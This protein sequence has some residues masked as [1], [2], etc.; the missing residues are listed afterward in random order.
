MGWVDVFKV[1]HVT[2]AVTFFGFVLLGYLITVRKQSHPQL[3]LSTNQLLPFIDSIIFSFL[4]LSVFWGTVLVY[5][6]HFTFHTPWVVAAY[7]LSATFFAVYGLIIVLRKKICHQAH[8]KFTKLL[9]HLL[10]AL[11]FIM[12]IF[13]IHDAVTKQTY[14]TFLG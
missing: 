4:L 12:L 14:L 7:L 6:K 11:I 13:I 5:P 9:L 8:S 10:Y 3:T 1:I 2:L